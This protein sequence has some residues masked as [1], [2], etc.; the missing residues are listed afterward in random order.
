MPVEIYALI[1]LIVRI[2][3]IVLIVQVILIQYPLLKAIND[4]HLYKLRVV[5]LMTSLVLLSSN[6]IPVIIDSSTVIQL[7]LPFVPPHVTESILF[8]ESTN[9]VIALA[10][11]VMLRLIYKVSGEVDQ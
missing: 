11:A 2:L 1:L 4:P 5:L 3:A 10:A 8:Y 7:M 6:V 9:A